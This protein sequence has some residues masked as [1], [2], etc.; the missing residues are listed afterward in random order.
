MKNLAQN[1]TFLRTKMGLKQV[2]LAEKLSINFTTWSDYERGKSLPK[3]ESLIQI[4]DFFQVSVDV[5]LRDSLYDVHPTGENGSNENGVKSPPNSPPNS[6]P[7][8]T[9]TAFL[10]EPEEEYG[11][12]NNAEIIQIQR[13]TINTQKMLIE[14]LSA[15]LARATEDLS[16]KKA[17]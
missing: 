1:L 11:R 8:S 5:L 2:E 10:K 17:V 4:S 6:P 7:K 15:Q 14:T 9:K 12:A 3:L 13:E 16:S